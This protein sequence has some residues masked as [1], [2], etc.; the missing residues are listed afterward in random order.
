MAKKG[1]ALA[2][3]S[4]GRL[5][6]A[7]R[8]SENPHTKIPPKWH[9]NPVP[10]PGYWYAQVTA[11]GPSGQADFADGRYWAKR[12]EI[13]NT[14]TQ[15]EAPLVWQDYTTPYPLHIVAQNLLNTRHVVQ[16][17]QIIEVHAIRSTESSTTVRY[18][19]RW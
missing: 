5:A 17:D 9:P 19:F 1:F 12:I 18:Y 10:Q 8:I 14:D 16:V 11:V 13:A 3:K 7:I 4:M 2:K 15:T 6:T